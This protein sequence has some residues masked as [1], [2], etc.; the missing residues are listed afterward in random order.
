MCLGSVV[1]YSNIYGRKVY[2][3]N[4]PLPLV[5]HIAF[6]VIDR[7]SN[8]IQI[9]PTSLC[10]HNCIFCSVDAGPASKFRRV[11]YIV[12]EGWLYRWVKEVS[13]I[14]GKGVEALIDGVGEPLAHPRIIKLVEL[15]RNVEEIKTISIETHGGS[16]SLRLAERLENAGLN[17]INLSIDTI[18]KEKA[19]IL[20]G[21]PWYD[22]ERVL[23]VVE[24]V[25]KQTNIDVILT[26]VLIPG[27]NENDI[28]AIIRWAARH[29]LGEKSGLPTGVLIQKYEVH[30][31]GRKPRGI[32][33]WSWKKFYKFLRRIEKEEGYRLVITPKEL[34]FRKAPQIE[35]PFNIG[36]EIIACILKEGWL[37]GE[38]LAV[39]KGCS[40]AITIVSNRQLRVG[41][42]LRVKIIRDKDNI[43][44]ARPLQQKKR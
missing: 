7:G 22:I 35:K 32:R 27:Y 34:G 4:S 1:E 33:A 30:R 41:E 19:K 28:K 3:I 25:V 16:L 23:S 13:R 37:K 21:S 43:F 12:N 29:K 20:T 38:Y 18:E 42:R 9:R 10:F 11:E 26:P 14:K 6:G 2:Y 15:L 39:D 24:K 40:R 31:F 36:D 5:G 17:R 8:V 44:I